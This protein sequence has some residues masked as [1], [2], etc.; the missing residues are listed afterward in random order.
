MRDFFLLHSSNMSKPWTYAVLSIIAVAP[1]F[2]AGA[3]I[4]GAL[5]FLTWLL[6]FRGIKID[7]HSP[8]S[9][10]ALASLLYFFV[11]ALLVLRVGYTE[12]DLTAIFAFSQF[13]YLALIMPFLA[14]KMLP[15]SFLLIGRI[16]TIVTMVAFLLAL[17]DV[18]WLKHQT[19]GFYVDIP[20]KDG[21]QWWLGIQAHGRTS[22]LTGNPNALA[23]LLFPI[24]FLSL[25]GW[26]DKQRLE[27]YMA[28]VVIV[29]GLITTV[30]FA[31]NRISLV[32]A[33]ILLILCSLFLWQVDK[34]DAKKFV[35]FT[36]VLISAVAGLLWLSREDSGFAR[37]IVGM[38]LELTGDAGADG[39]VRQRILMLGASWQAF[40]DS[41][42]FGHGSQ[43]KYAA[44]LPFLQDTFMSHITERR[45]PHNIFATHAVAGGLIGLAV[46]F[47]LLITPLVSAWQTSQ[48]QTRIERIFF[49]GVVSLSLIT[50]GMAEAMFYNDQKNTL[51]LMLWLVGL[52]AYS[53]SEI[54]EK[55]KI[56]E[57]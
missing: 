20:W 36:G 23:T 51:Y 1:I 53:K 39:S 27:K 7:T 33:P 34:K 26:Q 55:G 30:L 2:S 9:K 22:L 43:N 11:L 45:T 18:V 44:L 21:K 5:M 19:L 12:Q 32:A 37:R 17:I 42:V 47:Y 14:Q 50:L 13:F 38:L 8:V 10:L 56:E 4:I 25:S 57:L 48:Q 24:I 31:G 16:A 40:L 6:F 46:L 54:A 15:I 52:C 49:A 35:L 28:V 41:P 3:T 29:L